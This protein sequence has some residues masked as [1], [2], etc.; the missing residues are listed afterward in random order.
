MCTW[1]SSVHLFKLKKKFAN[2]KYEE[3]V[4]INGTTINK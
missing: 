2:K 1:F 3:E 4:L